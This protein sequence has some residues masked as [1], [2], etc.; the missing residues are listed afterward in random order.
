VRRLR[1]PRSAV[2]APRGHPHVRGDRVADLTSTAVASKEQQMNPLRRAI[3]DGDPVGMAV[4]RAK[5]LMD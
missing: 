4:E 1:L 3:I 2:A 5:E